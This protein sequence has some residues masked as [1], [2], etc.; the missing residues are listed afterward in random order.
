MVR[1]LR[2][3]G[4]DA[5]GIDSSEYAA[6]EA[7]IFG[8]QLADASKIPYLDHSFEMA[9]SFDVLEHIADHEPVCR[10]LRRVA[11][12]WI[13]VEIVTSEKPCDDE[14]HQ[15]LRPRSYW[16]DLLARDD[17]ESADVTPYLGDVWW[18]NQRETLIV[19][20]RR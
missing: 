3:Q 14:T 4:I 16:V 6:R 19:L 7:S 5:T 13:V 11:D 20:K 8:C 1:A 10:E 15:P 18:F 2:G 9:T 12:K 17:W